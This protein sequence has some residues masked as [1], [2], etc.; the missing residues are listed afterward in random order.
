VL[1]AAAG[2]TVTFTGASGILELTNLV[3]V[4]VMFAGFELS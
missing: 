4:S 1:I 2:G 3:G